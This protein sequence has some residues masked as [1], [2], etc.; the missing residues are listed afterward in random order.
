MIVILGEK[1]RK[2]IKKIYKERPESIII[3][4]MKKTGCSG[5]E[6]TVEIGSMNRNII[7]E[8]H[9]DVDIGIS[10]DYLESYDGTLIDY[11]DDKFESKFTFNNPNVK[12][13]CGCGASVN[14]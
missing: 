4:S 8:K 14:F 9:I 2:Q 3:F 12:S 7:V 1:A 10:K 6:Y 13:M 11:I 5:F